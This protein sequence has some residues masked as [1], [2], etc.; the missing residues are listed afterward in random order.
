MVIEPG[1]NNISSHTGSSD[2]A[3]APVRTEN[4]KTASPNKAEAKDNVS[5][6]AQGQAINQIEAE[7]AQTPEVD[8]EKV[9]SA[10]SAIAAGRYNID[11][12]SIANKIL[13]QD[14]LF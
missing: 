8:M 10:K 2:K 14:Q 11:S 3:K 5:L 1:S 6:S 7:I 12:G 4:S 13:E 9:E